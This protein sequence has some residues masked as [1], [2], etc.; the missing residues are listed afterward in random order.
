MSLLD[1]M[2]TSNLSLSP[3]IAH[4]PSESGEDTV[5]EETSDESDVVE[6]HNTSFSSLT[7]LT[8]AAV[9]VL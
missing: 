1:Y 5:S 9:A 2:E 6:D 8:Q 7:C 3:Q 4:L